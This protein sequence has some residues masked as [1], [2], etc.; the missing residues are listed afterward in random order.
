MATWN[1]EEIADG[2]ERWIK[3]RRDDYLQSDQQWGALDSLL[4]E[5]RE[6]FVQGW[7]PW[8]RMESDGN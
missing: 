3:Y 5:A 1:S 6:A 8:Q 4:D 2:I 7:M